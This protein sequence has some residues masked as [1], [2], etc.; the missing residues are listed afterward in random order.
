[1]QDLGHSRED[2]HNAVKSGRLPVRMKRFVEHQR[3]VVRVV[4]AHLLKVEG[5]RRK[6]SSRLGNTRRSPAT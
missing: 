1:M 6:E 4:D 3:R 2:A 5:T